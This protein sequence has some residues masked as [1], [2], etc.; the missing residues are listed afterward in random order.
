MTR[1]G[2]GQFEHFLE[3]GSDGVARQLL[4]VHIGGTQLHD[5]GIDSVLSNHAVHER[6]DAGA[7][8]AE[9]LL[10]LGDEVAQLVEFYFRGS[11]GVEEDA[12]G[13]GID[14]E[15]IVHTLVVV[16]QCR[17]CTGVVGLLAEDFRQHAVGF[18]LTVRGDKRI[19]IDH[20]IAHVVGMLPGEALHF[21]E[22]L[23]HLV[24]LD[25]ERAL[26]QRQP[27]RPPVDGLHALQRLDGLVVVVLLDIE[28]VEHLK[29]FLPAL[30]SGI[31]LLHHL[32]GV[33]VVVA[34]DVCL[35]QRLHIGHVAGFQLVG[36]AEAAYRAVL[37]LHLAE[38]LRLE[39]IYL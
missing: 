14:S 7:V 4:H 9:G 31:H 17:L 38:V 36:P 35:C 34:F 6:E 25:V 20:L 12:F 21:A 24:Q 15:G 32:D 23:V 11:R 8:A 16:A 10:A 3:G 30:V 33:G 39:E 13:D 19:G 28:A 29:Q 18:I 1:R 37:L 22:C 5:V 27:F 2:R 26:R